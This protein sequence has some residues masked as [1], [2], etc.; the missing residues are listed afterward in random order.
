MGSLITF[1]RR[2][3]AA[4]S[5]PSSFPQGP[6]FSSRRREGTEGTGPGGPAGDLAL[7]ARRGFLLQCFSPN[8]RDPGK[9]TFTSSALRNESHFLERLV[10]KETHRNR[11]L[12]FA[13]QPWACPLAPGCS[14]R[15]LSNSPGTR[16]WQFFPFVP[17]SAC[18]SPPLVS[19][20]SMD[21]MALGF[22]FQLQGPHLGGP[23]PWPAAPALPSAGGRLPCSSSCP[24]PPQPLSCHPPG[25]VGHGP[26][27]STGP[28]ST[29][30]LFPTVCVTVPCIGACPT[31]RTVSFMREL[32]IH[33][34]K[35]TR[36]VPG[37]Y[38]KAPC[39]H[40]EN[41]GEIE[42]QIIFVGVGGST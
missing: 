22:K 30:G 11:D 37:V 21:C 32:F 20:C 27:L 26:L 40:H 15:G 38:G 3:R 7:G 1:R 34:S 19:P 13:K 5:S 10:K 4:V 9:G 41:V 2:V 12:P 33:S 39:L 17:V 35:A 28:P 23:E 25:L 18:L 8:P 31:C 24:P 36:S 16:P 29:L 6:C 42:T 14:P